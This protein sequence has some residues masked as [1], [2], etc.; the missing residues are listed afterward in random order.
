[1]NEICRFN[2]KMLPGCLQKKENIEFAKRRETELRGRIEKKPMKTE[3]ESKLGDKTDWNN[4]G[5]FWGRRPIPGA[6][7]FKVRDR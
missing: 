6:T 3:E 2:V 4:R 7:K 1:M 5:N